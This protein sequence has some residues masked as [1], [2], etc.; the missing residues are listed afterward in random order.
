MSFRLSIHV[1]VA[2]VPV[3]PFS[4]QGWT[5]TQAN[6][7]VTKMRLGVRRTWG[8]SISIMG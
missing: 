1:L 6:V 7:L 4:L 3:H 8:L 2:C 5:G